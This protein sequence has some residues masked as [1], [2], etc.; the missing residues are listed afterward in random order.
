MKR[1]CDK[2]TCD[3]CTAINAR[4]EARV[5]AR[6]KAEEMRS[7]EHAERVRMGAMMWMLETN[8][9][10]KA[11][12][13]SHFGV[14][15]S[16]VEYRIRHYRYDLE[17]RSTAVMHNHRNAALA[18]RLRPFSPRFDPFVEVQPMTP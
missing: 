15:Y 11:E 13:A 17:S 18:N 12:I 16:A 1:Y 6:S 5:T 3:S 7:I 2:C 10:S 8:G 9:V 14:S 4:L